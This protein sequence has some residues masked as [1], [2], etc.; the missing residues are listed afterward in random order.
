MYNSVQGISSLS[1]SSWD[2]LSINGLELRDLLV[3]HWPGVAS[4]FV[5]TSVDWIAYKVDVLDLWKL[6]NFT[7]LIPRSDSIVAH[8]QGV[9]LDAWVKSFKLLNLIVW[10]PK[11]LEC[12]TNFIKT[13]N[14]L[15]IVSSKRKDFQLFQL[16]QVNNSINLIGRETEFFT[17]FKS[18]K[19]IVHFIN[20]RLLADQTN[21]LRLSSN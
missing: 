20:V 14:S 8:E 1:D 18:I 9:E 6:S 15:D 4:F 17:C 16:W 10:N 11:L 21:F 7:N 2:H 19:C 12:L 13:D 5:Q 3:N